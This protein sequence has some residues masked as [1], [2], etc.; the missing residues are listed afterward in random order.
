MTLH[1]S[2]PLIWT[3]SVLWQAGH[4]AP[5]MYTPSKSVGGDDDPFIQGETYDAVDKRCIFDWLDDCGS[6]KDNQVIWSSSPSGTACFVESRQLVLRLPILTPDGPHVLACDGPAVAGPVTHAAGFSFSP[7]GSLLVG[8][9]RMLPPEKL[10]VFTT[11]NAD[12]VQHEEPSPMQRDFQIWHFELKPET[13]LR[14]A[15]ASPP[16]A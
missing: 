11:H 5:D 15:V 3:Q 10:P 6:F 14:R 4:L 9:W 8:T 16:V 1:M 13:G 12:P 2:S 7:C